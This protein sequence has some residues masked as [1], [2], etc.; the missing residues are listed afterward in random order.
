M[1]SVNVLHRAGEVPLHGAHSVISGMLGLLPQ[2]K[3]TTCLH[4]CLEYCIE[5]S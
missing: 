3:Q 4:V 2:E 5:F 1:L